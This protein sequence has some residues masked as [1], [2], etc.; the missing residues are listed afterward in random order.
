MKKKKVKYFGLIF[1]LHLIIILFACFS[2]FL[3]SWEIIVVVSILLFIQY[4]LIGGCVLNKMQ[5][6]DIKDVVFLYRY[7]R[8]LGLKLNRYKFKIFI[9]YI[10]PFILLF[11]AIIWQIILNNPPLL[12]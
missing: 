7:L 2:P 5:F 10:L 12:F 6:D 11:I 1:W 9:R 4:Y 3:F 8:M